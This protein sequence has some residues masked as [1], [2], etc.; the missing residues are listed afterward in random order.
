MRTR[1]R[2]TREFFVAIQTREKDKIISS[3]QSENERLK[4]GIAELIKMYDNRKRLF[5]NTVQVVNCIE[6]ITDL[7]I[8]LNNPKP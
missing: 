7:K 1:S 5:H 3:L 4:S 2:Q 8:L 6:I